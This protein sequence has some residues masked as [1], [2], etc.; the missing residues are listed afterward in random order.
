MDNA[1]VIMLVG[2][3]IGVVLG[4]IDVA[5]S[6]FQSLTSWGVVVLG[7]ALVLLALT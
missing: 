6:N 5:R 1:E 4:G 7:I 3:A 2:G